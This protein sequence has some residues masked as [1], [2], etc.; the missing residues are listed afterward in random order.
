M[1]IVS[2][3]SGSII[4]IV[5]ILPILPLTPANWPQITYRLALPIMT[6]L[7]I[8]LLALVSSLAIFLMFTSSFLMEMIAD[9]LAVVTTGDA[10]SYSK[11]LDDLELMKF[12]YYLTHSQPAKKRWFFT[13]DFLSF[14]TEVKDKY[15]VE[16]RTFQDW[17][18]LIQPRLTWESHPSTNLRRKWLIISDKLINDHIKLQVIENREILS[19]NRINFSPT[20]SFK[21]TTLL[22]EINKLDS[23]VINTIFSYIRENADSFNIIR[24]SQHTNVDRF[25]I[26]LVFFVMMILGDIII[27]DPKYNS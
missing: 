23:F 27:V 26:T 22:N 12:Q 20:L 5:S 18:D 6:P 1:G 15:L 3:V 8:I 4:G 21:C 17:S 19:K 24:A 13:A 25:S 7:G 11:A 14:L 10:T 2:F 16:K 9:T